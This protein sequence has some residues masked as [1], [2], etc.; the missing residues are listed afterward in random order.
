MASGSVKQRV[1]AGDEV[2]AEVEGDVV[3]LHLGERP[4]LFTESENPRLAP[5]E[6][7]SVQ[8]I[9]E[10][11]EGADAVAELLMTD[12]IHA[13]QV[14]SEDGYT[15]QPLPSLAAEGLHIALR[16]LLRDARGR[17]EHLASK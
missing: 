2:V 13:A 15:Y 9:R 17:L 16:S 5:Y 11:I 6:N 3:T 14:Q 1:M 7:Q 12:A 8:Y 4:R 10:A